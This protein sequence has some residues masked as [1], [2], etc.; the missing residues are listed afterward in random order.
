MDAW[1]VHIGAM[2][3]L[4]VGAITL[5]Q[6]NAFWGQTRLGAMS[7]I[8]DF[9]VADDRARSLTVACPP[10]TLVDNAS[11]AACSR[12]AG[13]QAAALGAARD[14]VRTWKHHVRDMEMLRMGHMSPAT[15][16]RMWLAN[17]HKGVDQLQAYHRAAG[18]VTGTCTP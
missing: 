13:Q 9:Q 3:K 16:T 14:A 7:N 10:A 8:R 6:A 2:N 15:A 5:A 11:V 1:A 4:V 18:R 17:W 12:R